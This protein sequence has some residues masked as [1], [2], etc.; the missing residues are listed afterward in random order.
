MALSHHAPRKLRAIGFPSGTLFWLTLATEANSLAR[1]SKRTV[2]L[3]RAA[4]HYHSQVSGSFN[5]LSGV[6][7][8][9]PSRY[10][11]AIG[12][13]TCLGL[14]VDVP[15]IRASYPRDTT[16]EHVTSFSSTATGLSPSM[17]LLSRRLRVDER[18]VKDGP[19][20]TCPDHFWQDSDCP[21]PLSVALTHGIPIGFSSSRY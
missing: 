16:L 5:S 18:R 21:L 2:Q 20:S 6:L 10:S 19:K 8:N 12:L 13:P 7:F 9:F 15:H 4:P 17:A 1:Y 3:R 14:E 11:Y